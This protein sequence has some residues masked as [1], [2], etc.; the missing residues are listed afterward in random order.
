MQHTDPEFVSRRALWISGLLGLVFLAGL[1]LLFL[2]GHDA[3]SVA[4]SAAS[5]T[6]PR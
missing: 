4:D 3:Q 2:L 6:P 1:V 5:V